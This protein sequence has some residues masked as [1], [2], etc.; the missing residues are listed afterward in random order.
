[1]TGTA[2]GWLLAAGLTALGAA[3]VWAATASL[4]NYLLT[5]I[6]FAGINVMLAV[7]LSLSNGLTG[8][9]SLGHPAFMMV[10]GYIAAI[11]TFPANRKGFM[12]PDLPE[13]L[14]AQQ[15]PLLPA[16]LVGGAVAGLAAIMAG[17]PVLRL[18]GHYLAVATLGLIFILRAVVNNLDGYTRGALGLSGI[19]KL[20]DLWWVYAWV[21]ITLFVCWRIKHS[22]LGRTMMAM[23]ENEMAAA[24]MG[25]PLARTRLM[26]FAIGA[27]FAGIAGGLWAHLVTNLTPTSL[28]VFLAF[29]LVVMVVLG[30]QGSL[31]GAALAAV[32]LSAIANLLRPVEQSTGIYGMTQIVVALVLIG[33]LIFR[34]QGLFGSREPGVLM[35][36][37]GNRT[38]A[39]TQTTHLEQRGST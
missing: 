3:A 31:A 5:L 21:V 37:P 33:V 14:A 9:F 19:P 7:S 8:L 6:A 29:Q 36:R 11:L 35:R 28:G 16:L 38:A 18:R 1:M 12:L 32:G 2:R 17:F 15:W 4:N 27:V 25:V 26:A 13:W 20:T 23:R 30:G 39:S 10:G 22:S 34:P 24:C